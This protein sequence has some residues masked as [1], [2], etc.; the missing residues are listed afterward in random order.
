MREFMVFIVYLFPLTA[1]APVVSAL[2]ADHVPASI[3]DA[4][5]L[6]SVKMRPNRERGKIPP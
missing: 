3:P 6:L 2:R 4:T 5:V 1:D